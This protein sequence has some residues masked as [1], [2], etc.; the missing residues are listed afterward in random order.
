MMELPEIFKPGHEAERI[1]RDVLL[2]EH[3]S[4]HGIRCPA[5]VSLPITGFHR[6]VMAGLSGCCDFKYDL[7]LEQLSFDF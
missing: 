1:K 7:S 5:L 2:C 6:H 3:C 4:N